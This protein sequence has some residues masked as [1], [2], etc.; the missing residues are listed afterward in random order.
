MLVSSC[1]TDLINVILPLF[2]INSS[3][4][5]SY[6]LDANDSTRLEVLITVLLALTTFKFV[7]IGN[8]PQV[9][10]PTLLDYYVLSCYVFCFAVIVIQLLTYLGI[11]DEDEAPS[12]WNFTVPRAWSLGPSEQGSR[13]PVPLVFGAVVWGGYHLMIVL[14]FWALKLG[15]AWYQLPL[16]TVCGKDGIVELGHEFSSARSWKQARA[17]RDDRRQRV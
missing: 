2:I 5:A 1:S 13:V 6:G 14:A 9:N 8:L 12:A 7:I 4:L 15:R 17:E 16:R 10:Y 11:Y 3:L